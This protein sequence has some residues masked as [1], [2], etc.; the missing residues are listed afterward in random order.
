M[1]LKWFSLFKNSYIINSKTGEIDLLESLK[2]E[3]K[4][5]LCDPIFYFCICICIILVIMTAM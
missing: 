4:D 3:W 1:K 5:A 2:Q